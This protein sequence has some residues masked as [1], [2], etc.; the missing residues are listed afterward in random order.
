VETTGLGGGRVQIGGNVSSQFLSGL[1][2]AA[3]LAQSNVTIEVDGPLVSAPYVA[4]TA[5]MMRRFGVPVETWGGSSAAEA[6]HFCVPLVPYYTAQTFNVEP[7]ASAAGYFLAAAAITGGEV[8]IPGL[9]RSSLQGDVA[10]ARILEEMG[11]R[12]FMSENGIKLHGL[13][14]RGIEADMGNISDCVMTL[15]AVACF[16]D[17]PS[18][19]RNVAHIRYKETDRLAALATELDRVGAEVEELSDGLRITP[20]PLHGATIETYNDH[21]MAMS[22]ALIGL[23]VPGITIRNPG[24]VAKTYPDF[25]DDLEKL[26]C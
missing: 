10:F 18:T 24:C 7:D 21:R 23:Q 8:T 22:L 3:P 14:L 1:L 6:I 9:G 19:I 5:E 26:R 15:A 16:A 25:F 17:A 2:M 12:L 13:A 4:M 20:R 11:A